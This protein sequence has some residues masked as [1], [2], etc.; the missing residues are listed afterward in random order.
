[1]SS[2]I[3]HDYPPGGGACGKSRELMDKI[4]K[5]PSREI[6]IKSFDKYENSYL[7]YKKN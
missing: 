6:K 3:A 1:V 7:E 4:K 2:T 5:M